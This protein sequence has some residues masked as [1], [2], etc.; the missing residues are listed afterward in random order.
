MKKL[1]LLISAML[2]ILV[3]VN[4]YAEEQNID[5][6]KSILTEESAEN[7]DELLNGAEE[8]YY[9]TDTCIERK[10]SR[11]IN[12]NEYIGIGTV[13]TISEEKEQNYSTITTENSI[14]V[15]QA[16]EY[17]S[18]WQQQNGVYDIAFTYKIYVTQYIEGAIPTKLC[19]NYS[20]VKI[21][22]AGS[23]SRI[24]NKIISEIRFEEALGMSVTYR[25]SHIINYPTSGTVYRKGFNS[26][27]YAYPQ[28]I[29]LLTEVYLSDD[30]VHQ[31]TKNASEIH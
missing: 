8:I 18:Y 27:V 31:F 14:I 10:Q 15:L 26:P 16:V 19:V 4:V 20:E 11:T 1:I 7:L 24:V 2:V 12:N 5:S 13:K 25:G 30:S 6:V 3:G 23:D 21:I 9:L 22:D 17:P 28:A 29:I